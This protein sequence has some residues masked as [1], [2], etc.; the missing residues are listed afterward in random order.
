MR[1]HGEKL[2]RKREQAIEALLATATIEAAA[3]KCGVSAGTLRN[4]L[5]LEA[6]FA[7]YHARRVA[8]LDQGVKILQHATSQAAATLVGTLRAAK[9]ADA[10]KAAQLIFELTI[11]G[12]ELVQLAE[13]VRQLRLQVEEIKDARR[14][15][16]T[17]G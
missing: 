8:L 14:R 6:F 7:E 16:R 1:G 13:Q 17:I 3:Q 12:T 2:S 4:W 10:I 15:P 5:A 11:R 9:D